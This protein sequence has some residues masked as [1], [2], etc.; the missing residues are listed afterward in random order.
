MLCAVERA[1][2]PGG[3]ARSPVSFFQERTPADEA[4]SARDR[5]LDRNR[6]AAHYAAVKATREVKAKPK[7]LDFASDVVA[8]VD[9]EEPER[10]FDMELLEEE[11]T[12][13]LH[14]R[15]EDRRAAASMLR[16]SEGEIAARVRAAVHL[17]VGVK[18]TPIGEGA[19]HVF[20]LQPEIC[21]PCGWTCTCTCPEA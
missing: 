15:I 9:M 7:A 8:A 3:T 4:R 21:C 1:P 12:H 14:S 5:R 20:G 17:L 6:Q 2:T 19:R 10:S 11:I 18:W 16:N 13:S